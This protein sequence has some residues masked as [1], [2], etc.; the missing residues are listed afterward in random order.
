MQARAGPGGHHRPRS[1]SP[2]LGSGR[3]A[4]EHVA[5]AER[6]RRDRAGRVGRRVRRPGDGVAHPAGAAGRG[7]LGRSASGRR[8]RARTPTPRS[9]E[10]SRRRPWDSMAAE[11]AQ[12]PQDVRE[13]STS[14]NGRIS[15]PCRS[16][17][18]S[19]HRPTVCHQAG[20]RSRPTDQPLRHRPLT[21][22]DMIRA[23]SSPKSFGAGPRS[24]TSTASR[25]RPSESGHRIDASVPTAMP[26]VPQSV[27]R[28]CAPPIMGVGGATGPGIAP[29]IPGP[30]ITWSRNACSRPCARVEA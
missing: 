30:P 12:S 2:R 15:I 27:A 24:T 20:A 14:L 29:A 10:R 18:H 3:G 6:R 9:Q 23:L 17:A 16:G 11:S 1:G 13:R 25:V 28:R 8:V 7:R 19:Q 21:C 22:T 5:P 4:A 26:P